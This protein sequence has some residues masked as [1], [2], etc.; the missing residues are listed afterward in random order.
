M[1]VLRVTTS[2]NARREINMYWGI[3]H[4]F[5]VFEAALVFLSLAF[6]FSFDAAME[7]NED[8][9]IYE[10]ACSSVRN[11]F[12]LCHKV[13]DI[14]IFED[15]KR[16]TNIHFKMINVLDLDFREGGKFSLFTL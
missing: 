6:G 2:L 5:T 4:F 7:I 3:N 1:V 13:N 12:N 16:R 14:T 10:D 9:K 15:N 11:F 8:S